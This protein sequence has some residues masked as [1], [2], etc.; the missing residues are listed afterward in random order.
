MVEPEIDESQRTVAIAVD[1]GA[2]DP[3]QVTLNFTKTQLWNQQNALKLMELT[4]TRQ[5]ASILQGVMYQLELGMQALVQK[6]Q[7]K[8]E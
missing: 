8:Q 4:T 3:K 1:R 7:R 6:N 5:L 2:I